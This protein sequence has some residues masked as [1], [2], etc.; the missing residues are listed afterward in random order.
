[1]VACYQELTEKTIEIIRSLPV[2]IP[3][4]G[5]IAG[6]TRC[7]HPEAARARQ[8]DNLHYPMGTAFLKLGV[9]GIAAFAERQLSLCENAKEAGLLSGIAA[10]YREIAAYFSRYVP[11]L[12]ARLAR[13]TDTE[14]RERLSIMRENMA[15]LSC[16][17][18]RTFA[19]A[20]QLM[21]LMGRIRCMN[22]NGACIGRLDVQLY[23]VYL[24]DKA[25]GLTDEAAL[26]WI[27]QYWERLNECAS[28]DTLVNVMVGGQ[29]AQGNDTTNELSLLMLRASGMVRKSEPHI[30]VRYHKNAPPELMEEAYR[31]QMLGHGQAT[32]YNDEVIL[33]AFAEAGIPPEQACCYANDGCTEIVFDGL[34]DIKFNHTDAVAVLELALNNGSLTPKEARE[35]PYFH[36]THQK[37]YYTP[38]VQCGFASGQTDNL[39]SYEEFYR[40]F[41]RQYRHQM[42]FKMSRLW[43]HHESRKEEETSLILNGTFESVL[44]SRRHALGGGL[45]M[46]SLM[47]FAG[48]IPTV[49][50]CL[51]AMKKVVFEEKKASIPE[52]KR[53]LAANFEGYEALRGMLLRA[54]KFGNDDDEVDAIAADIA[55]HVCD[56][57]DEFYERTGVRIFMA[58]VG[59]R[60]LQEAY[61]VGATP[62]GRKYAD[63]VAEHYCATPGRA[64]KG[65]T[66]L[67]NSITKAPLYR[68]CGVAATH[69]TLPA[70]MASNEQEGLAILRALN[71][72]A[73]QQGAVM[74]NIAIYDVESLRQAQLHPEKYED[75][76][77]RVWGFS[78]R[79]IDLSR[80]M[81]EHVIRRVLAQ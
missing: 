31:L 4:K 52:L 37:K 78:A 70:S 47:C 42:E 64:V 28:G 6:F 7:T 43:N 18:P 65:P 26:D 57:A 2:E 66:A 69:I 46:S 3:Q 60:F 41:L 34:S 71:M 55:G 30:N 16:D 5:K 73:V 74:L 59:W 79:F 14:E 23:P 54:P 45:P 67:L 61:G 10:V 80:E 19:Q 49:A 1:M 40:I 15:I 50:D 36:R 24:E 33:P 32:L 38:S 53:A 48:S 44:E 72:A 22:A 13:E 75:L 77:V 68:A 27:C 35:V 8:T 20:V 25:N 21:Y 76:I 9:Q 17:R 51:A 56:W 63:P 62:D 29:D 11:E 12:D 81:Q 39:T 58:L